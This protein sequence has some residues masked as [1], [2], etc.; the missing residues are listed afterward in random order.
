MGVDVTAAAAEAEWETSTLFPQ[1][2]PMP[3]SSGPARHS[4]LSGSCGPS[5][6]AAGSISGLRDGPC[7]Q[8]RGGAGGP[9]G[10]RYKE[11]RCEE[12]VRRGGQ[13]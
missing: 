4:P 8:V 11:D 1:G 2:T 10:V 9:R 5:H 7:G 6:L 13:T 12:R 3:T